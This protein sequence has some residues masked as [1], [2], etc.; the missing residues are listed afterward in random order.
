MASGG[1]L[2]TPT[3]IATKVDPQT[4]QTTSRAAHAAGLAGQACRASCPA[5]PLDVPGRA[6]AGGVAGLPHPMSP[7]SPAGKDKREWQD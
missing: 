2:S 7:E 5:G 6:V 1:M 3:R 4:T